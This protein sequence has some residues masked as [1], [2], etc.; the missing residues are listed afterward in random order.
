MQAPRFIFV[1]VWLG[2]TA[3]VPAQYFYPKKDIAFAQVV[4]GGGFETVINLTNRGVS[5]YV[6]TLSLFRLD[7]TVWTP[8]LSGARKSSREF[9]RLEEGE[10]QTE[11]LPG[12]TVTFRLTGSELESGAA[13]LLSDDL[14]LDNLIEANLTYRVLQDGQVSDSVGLAP[15]REFYR[16]ALPFEKFA[17]VGLAL[18]NGDASGEITANVELTLFSAAGEQRATEPL[19]LGPRSHRAR[20]LNEFFPGQTL[21]GGTVEIASDVPI[22]GTALTLSGGEFSSLPLEPAPIH[23]SVRLETADRLAT[24]EL[25]LWAQ[26]SFLRGYLA[27]TA[28]DEDSFVDPEFSLVHGELEAGRLRLTL[29]VLQDPFS[30][31]EATLSLG[32]DE[33]S[34]GAA[35][36]S[37]DW[38]EL[39][40]DETVLKGTYVLTR[41]DDG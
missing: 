13:L 25:V 4:V 12:E 33:F 23:Y 9:P 10:F 32:H 39:F 22:F 15:S 36:V 38:I 19:T 3:A 14:L 30:T 40:P 11:I 37:G 8:E 18:V 5:P 41:R 20:F 35:A 31:G 26:G 2:F 24:G 28:L 1:L 27:I 17:Q 21:E 16:A 29:T 34:F 7:N 6:G